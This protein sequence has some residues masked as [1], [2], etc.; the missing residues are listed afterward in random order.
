MHFG[1]I[2]VAEASVSTLMK[3]I[4]KVIINPIIFFLFALALVYFLYGVAQYLLN[5]GNENVRK[6]SK[7]H[8]LYGVVGLFIM[9]AVFGIMNL[10]LNTLGEKNI[11]VQNTG[12]YEIL[13]NGSSSNNQDSNNFN[14]A[15]DNLNPTQ[16]DTTNGPVD[17]RSNK[18]LDMTNV[19]NQQTN[20]FNISPFKA[21][22]ATSDLCWRKEVHATGAT[23]Y[24]A[25][26]S[27]KSSASSFYSNINGSGA[28]SQYPL[29]FGI[30]TSY[31]SANKIYHAW[32]DARAPING[33]NNNDCVLVVIDDGSELPID[34]YINSTPFTTQKDLSTGNSILS[35]DYTSNSDYTRTVSSG[36]G[37]SL[38]LARQIAINNAF[39]A[40]SQSTGVDLS[41]LDASILEEKYVYNPDTGEY[42]YWVALQSSNN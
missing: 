19:Q 7:T 28:S 18:N 26:Q 12:N 30:L 4:N 37:S 15:G 3:S 22:Y 39:L 36:V 27:V 34:N 35:Q 20:N 2:P 14:A 10:L 21:Q 11:K 13:N 38:E 6:T 42:E 41:S 33:G 29:N 8:M 5:P 25:I 40:L 32:M 31:D 23:E 24:Q 1:F 9:V 16:V 17:I